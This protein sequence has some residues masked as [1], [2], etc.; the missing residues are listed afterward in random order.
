MIT[1]QFLAVLKQVADNTKPDQPVLVLNVP[2]SH[3]TSHP[4]LVYPQDVFDMVKA[5]DWLLEY[6]GT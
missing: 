4:Y 5:F 2:P 1:E 3:P 6:Y